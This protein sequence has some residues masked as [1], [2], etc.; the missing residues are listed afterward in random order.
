M[1][2]KDLDT[3]GDRLRQAVQELK[4]EHGDS[5]AASYVTLS[6]GGAVTVPTEESG[7]LDLIAIADK[8][9]YAAK[10][11]GRNKSIVNE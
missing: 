8:N 5:F 11:K 2:V 6:V 9:L 3:I 7:L 4:I 10:A 1:Q